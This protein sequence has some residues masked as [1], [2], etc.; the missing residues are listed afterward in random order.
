MGSNKTD[1]TKTC[2]IIRKVFKL[3]NIEFSHYAVQISESDKTRRDL[4]NYS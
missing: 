3:N 1:Y 2:F 4:F